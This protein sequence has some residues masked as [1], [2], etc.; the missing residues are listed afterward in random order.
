TSLPVSLAWETF[1]DKSGAGSLYEMRQ[2]IEHYRRTGS[3][4]FLDYEIGCVILTQPVFFRE[5]DWFGPPGWK[6]NIQTG[7]SYRL[8]T[9]AGRALWTSAERAMANVR[10][11]SSPIAVAEPAARYGLPI[12]VRPR[13]GQG[14][15]QT[16]VLDAY[17]RRC[18]IS[19][20]KV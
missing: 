20:E 5:V 1:G 15:F 4:R 8:D 9:D 16:A 12:F 11:A 6:P 17:D 18:S 2:R 19:G 10:A 7:S 14:S 3:E 13:L